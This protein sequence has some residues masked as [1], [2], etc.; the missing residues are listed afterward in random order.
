MQSKKPGAS[1]RY[2]A[3]TNLPNFLGFAFPHALY[4]YSLS[5][6]NKAVLPLCSLKLSFKLFFVAFLFQNVPKTVP[7]PSPR[8]NRR[9]LLF[10]TTNVHKHLPWPGGQEPICSGSSAAHKHIEIMQ[11]TVLYTST[12]FYLNRDAFSCPKPYNGFPFRLQMKHTFWSCYF[13]LLCTYVNW[14][15]AKSQNKWMPHNGT[16]LQQPT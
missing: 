10:P 6:H 9:F 11:V 3:Q 14:V 2:N 12:Y 5:N 15:P 7:W 16:T 8:H 1:T 4:S 13:L